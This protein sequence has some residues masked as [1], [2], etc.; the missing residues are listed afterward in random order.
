MFFFLFC[1]QSVVRLN[2]KCVVCR[3]IGKETSHRTSALVDV[4]K[5]HL[6][7]QPLI[8]VKS[9]NL[10]SAFFKNY[11]QTCMCHR[12]T[13]VRL[14]VPLL[15]SLFKCLISCLYLVFVSGPTSTI[16]DSCKYFKEASHGNT[17][18]SSWLICAANV[19]LVL[20]YTIGVGFFV[21][22]LKFALVN[23]LTIIFKL[24]NIPY[25]TLL[26]LS[27]FYCSRSYYSFTGKY[28]DLAAKL[29]GFLKKRVQQGDNQREVKLEYN[30]KKVIPKYLFDKACR[31]V[32][33]LAENICKLLLRIC[34]ILC[35]FYLVYISLTKTPSIPGRVKAVATFLIA[36][37]PYIVQIVILKTGGEMK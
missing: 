6:R 22:K 23:Y 3:V 27:A 35:F 15:V 30:E 7:I 11:L 18:W 19:F 34:L 16:W 20:S 25:L 37:M 26:V 8:I 31:E 10:F 29:Y 13:T 28:D 21:L 36:S 33:P 14:L 17:R 9:W 2:M 1:F 5:Q 24:E 4:I 12:R 32:M